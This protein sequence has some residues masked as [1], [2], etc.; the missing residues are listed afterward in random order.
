MSVADPQLYRTV[1]QELYGEFC[2]IHRAKH[3]KGSFTQP[4]QICGVGG[5][6][7]NVCFV[8]SVDIAM[9]GNEAGGDNRESSHV[10]LPSKLPFR[11]I[12]NMHPT[13]S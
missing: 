3:R 6:T 7:T 1:Q 8:S 9:R 10:W 13:T 11:D 12:R 5:S 2:F 4:C